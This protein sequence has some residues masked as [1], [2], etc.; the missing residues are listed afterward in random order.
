MYVDLILIILCW[1]MFQFYIMDEIQNYP[2]I[3][4]AAFAI[5][6]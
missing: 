3:K 1:N 6:N 5:L 2:D 4:L